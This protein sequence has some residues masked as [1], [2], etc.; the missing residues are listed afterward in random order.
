MRKKALVSVIAAGALLFALC[1]SASNPI[2]SRKADLP[3]HFLEAIESQARGVYSRTIPLVPVYIS[4]DSLQESSV[5]YT[6]YYFP[7][8]TVGMSYTENDGYNQEKPL[9]N[10]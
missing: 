4:I 5:Y 10:Q 9:T 3:A 6:I 2:I 8:G 7:F 1:L